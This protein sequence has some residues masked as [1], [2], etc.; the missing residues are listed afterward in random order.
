MVDDNAPLTVDELRWIARRLV[1]SLTDVLGLAAGR[2]RA[3]PKH[4]GGDR[5]NAPISSITRP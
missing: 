2:R 1:A 3:P 4:G 5:R